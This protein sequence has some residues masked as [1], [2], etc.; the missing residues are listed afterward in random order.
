[1][2]VF[3]Q[4]VF[5]QLDVE[6]KNKLDQQQVVAGLLL[7]TSRTNTEFDYDIIAWY[8]IAVSSVKCHVVCWSGL[9]LTGVI[10]YHALCYTPLNELKPGPSYW[11]YR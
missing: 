4:N 6:H 1:M 3:Y 2:L 5:N 7:T 11:C 8:S 10:V 9:S